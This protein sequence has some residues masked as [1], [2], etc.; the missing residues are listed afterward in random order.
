MN[1]RPDRIITFAEFELNT[2]QLSIAR[3][4]QN[5][6]K[7]ET[8]EQVIIEKISDLPLSVNTVAKQQ[9]L[10]E[11]V[12]NE[13]FV[14][15][16]SEEQL[17]ELV[18]KV[19]P[20]MRFRDEGFKLD[21]EKLN[22]RDL[23]AE[24][25]YIQ[26][27][28][29]N[30]RVTVQKYREKVEALIKRLEEENPILQK[31]K[32]GENLAPKEVEQLADTL[33]QYDPY[34][35]EENLQRAYDARRVQ[36]LDLIKYIMGIGELITFPEKVSEAFAEFIAA[37]NTLTAKQIQFLDALKT[38]IIENGRLDKKDLTRE[39]FTRFH[40]KGFLGLFKPKEREEILSLASSLL[41]HA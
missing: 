3:L 15:K 32:A 28:P 7:I 26:F 11:E 31:V 20:L 38:F 40:A 16:A 2:I 12:L 29:A 5:G 30:E 33:E 19:A 9:K 6:E 17:K 8:L 35:T 25:Q 13:G 10:I 39:P 36:F 24:K 27:G 22:L 37:H 21:Q 18:K 14:H 34:P 4:E 23:T 1:D 41:T